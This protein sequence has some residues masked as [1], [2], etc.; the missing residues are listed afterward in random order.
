MKTRQGKHKILLWTVGIALLG[1]AFY[2]TFELGRYRAGYSKLDARRATDALREEIRTRD[3]EIEDLHRQQAILET[4]REIDRETYAQVEA[5]LEQLQARIQAKDKELAFYQGMVSPSD[6][7]AGLRIQDLEVVALDSEQHYV[8]R[9]IL[10]QAIV[11]NQRVRGTIRVRLAGIE[12]DGTAQYD[13]A[14]L[15]G[16][17]EQADLA[18]GFRYF[19]SLERALVLPT[20]FDP[21]TIEVE[22]TPR[23][24][25]G[26]EITQSF[27][28]MP[29]SG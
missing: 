9:L 25:K 12:R 15:L 28:W 24:P 8:L 29:A 27:P 26:D 13:L 6:G 23:E 14:D 4:S 20:G 22:I 7:A 21:T 5:N 19:Q 10:V 3:A 2:L 17:G 11:H 16:E 18:Y 1:A